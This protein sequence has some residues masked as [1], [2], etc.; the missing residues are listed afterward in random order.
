MSNFFKKCFWFLAIIV[1]LNV[2]YLLILLCFSPG[3][4]KIHEI[5]N[6]K[7]QNFETL[8]L[9]NSMALDGIDADYLSKNAMSTYNLSVAG[10][11]ISTS[12]FILEDYLKK[13]KKPKTVV[14]GLSS[15]I[16]RSFLNPVPFTNPEVEFFYHPNWLSN[17]T[18][19]PLFN[20]QWLAVDLIKILISKDHRNA[21]MILGQWKTQKVIADTSVFKNANATAIDYNDPF[22]LQI[23]QL[24]E[25]Q[26][27]QVILTELPG[28]NSNRN[29]LLFQYAIT[30]KNQST[31][32]VYNLNNYKVSSAILNPATDWLAPDHLNQNGGM[33]ITEF[34]LKNVL[35]KESKVATSTTLQQ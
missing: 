35:Q 29:N 7:N 14:I 8:V 9:G 27:I 34:L 5:S 16:G 30:L 11:H 2:L 24:C 3:F 6:F 22:L 33:K 1:A 18:N 20:F 32:V 23:I 12:L 10:D 19:P 25:S 13:N 15:A 31:R 4:K 17:V 26:G 28:S 21:K